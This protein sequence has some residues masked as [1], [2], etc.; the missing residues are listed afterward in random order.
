M[1]P[2]QDHDQAAHCRKMASGCWSKLHREAYLNLAKA[3]DVLA[4]APS[5]KKATMPMRRVTL[6][7]PYAAPTPEGVAANEAYARRCV[8]DCLA[9]N[10]SASASHLLFTQAGIL[11][12]TKVEERALGIAAGMAWLPVSE[13]MVVYIDYGI[14]SG[15]SAAMDLALSMGIPI[16]ERRIGA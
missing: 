1:T 12:D 3:W 13:A 4:D 6:E 15:M 16:E 11:D 5:R 7:S 8:K 2:E 9:R 14:S 10:E